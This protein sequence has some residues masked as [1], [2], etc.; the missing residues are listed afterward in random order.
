MNRRSWKDYRIARWAARH[1]ILSI[2]TAGILIRILGGFAIWAADGHDNLAAKIVVVI[3]VAL[4][5]FGIGVLKWLSM[6]PRRKDNFA[7]Q[8]NPKTPD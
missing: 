1:P 2:F 3:G 5:V 7:V 4:S 6:R 8:P